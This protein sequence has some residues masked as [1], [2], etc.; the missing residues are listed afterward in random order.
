MMLPKMYTLLLVDD[1]PTQRRY[2][3]LLIESLGWRVHAYRSREL[4]PEALIGLRVDLALVTLLTEN[5]NGFE[6]GVRL[7]A[8]GIQRVAIV[9]KQPRKT[10]IQWAHALGL[11]GVVD[12]PNATKRLREQLQTLL[13]V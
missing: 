3:V 6:L 1:S 13:Q 5:S 10:D 4:I 7:Q 8:Y 11:L 12:A 2:L 9:T